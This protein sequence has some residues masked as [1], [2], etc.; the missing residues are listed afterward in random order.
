MARPE[1]FPV[2]PFL[3]NLPNLIKYNLMAN[4]FTLIK[5]FFQRQKAEPDNS[6][7]LTFLHAAFLISAAAIFEILASP[8]FSLYWLIFIF[9]VPLLIFL[10]KERNLFHLWAGLLTYRLI[11]SLGITYFVFDPFLFLASILIFSGLPLS[12]YFVK[13]LVNKNLAF[14]SLIILWPFWELLEAR[15]TA[16]PNFAMTTGS[17]LGPSIFLGLAA[18]GG[19]PTLIIFIIIINFLVFTIYRQTKN[20]KPI[21]LLIAA[22]IIIL[23]A[24]ALV[25]QLLLNKNAAD[26]ESLKNIKRLVLVSES[27]YFDRV[28]K[29]KILTSEQLNQ[30]IDEALAPLFNDLKSRDKDFDI[31]VLPESMI[32]LDLRSTT[33]QAAFDKFKISNNGILITKYGEF[34]KKLNKDLITNIISVQN[35]KRYNT[36]L[37]FNR[38]GELVDIFNKKNLVISG[39]YWP[40]GNWRPFYFYWVKSLDPNLYRQYQEYSFFN[41]SKS[42]SRGTTR[43][44]N[45]DNLIF[46]TAECSEIHYPDEMQA[47]V[48][49]GGQLILNIS[50]NLWVPEGISLNQ[51]LRLTDNLRRI[52]SVWLKVP[53][54][55]NG[56]RTWLSLA[57]PDGKITSAGYTSAEKNYNISVAEI[58][59]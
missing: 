57:T 20:K 6:K 32:D 44:V 36:I 52:E 14:L 22:S 26:Y 55:S 13:R 7:K 51:Y 18:F 50:S 37:F 35:G 30:T 41:P 17:S 27:G 58:K 1:T 23:V 56:R 24:G 10:E 4:H 39:E 8:P 45:F 42:F 38:N 28:F 5:R 19:L 34:A 9:A 46:A 11:A 48:K 21:K 12:F 49:L 16:L 43:V 47:R 53:V 25:S 54:T 15:Y 2:E 33:N 3:F 40:F 29:T 59:F 31:V